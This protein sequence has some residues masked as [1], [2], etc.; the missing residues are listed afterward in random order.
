[1]STLTTPYYV[2]LVILLALACQ[3]ALSRYRFNKKYKLP[4]RVPGLPIIGNT[5]QIPPLHQG[6]WGKA[7]AEKYGEM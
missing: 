2:A 3:Q 5:L 1:M 6:L 4:V 7:M